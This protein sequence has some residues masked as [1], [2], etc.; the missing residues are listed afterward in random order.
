VTPRDG[1][2]IDDVTARSSRVAED[3]VESGLPGNSTFVVAHGALLR[4][5]LAALMKA[6]DINLMW[7]MRLDNCSIT[8]IDIWGRRPSLYVLNDTHHC[9]VGS[10]EA[11][12]MLSFSS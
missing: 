12:A 5:L 1:E 7:K 11:I 10:D 9:R 3:I 4:A 6:E 8:V 2:A